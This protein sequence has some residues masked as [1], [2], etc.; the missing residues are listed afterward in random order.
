MDDSHSQTNQFTPNQFV[1]STGLCGL[2]DSKIGQFADKFIQNVM[3]NWCE[4]I[5]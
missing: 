1:N 5:T 2:D 3:E 4:I